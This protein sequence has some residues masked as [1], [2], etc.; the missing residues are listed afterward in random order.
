LTPATSNATASTANPTDRPVDPWPRRM[1]FL[2]VA[3]VAACLGAIRLTAPANL[4]DQDQERPA[5]YVLDA[6]KNGNWICQRDL[7][8]DI[9]SKP[10]LYTWFCAALTV[11]NGRINLATLYLPCVFAGFGVAWL[12]LVVGRKP[13]GTTAAMFGALMFMLTPAGLKLFGLARTDSLFALTVTAAALLAWRAWNRG[14]GWTWFWLLAALATLTKGPL[15]VVL[16]AFGLLAAVWERRSGVAQPVKGSHWLGAALFFLI[17][18]GWFYLAYLDQGQALVDKM[19]GKELVGNAIQNKKN[20]LPGTLIWQQPLFYLGRAAPWSLLA[21]CGVWRIWKR[22]SKQALER[23]FERFLCCWFLAGL[24]LFSLSSHQRADLLWPLMPAAAL[25]AGRELA[26][27]AA[28]FPA[29]RLR[30]GTLISVALLLIGFGIYYHLGRLRQPAIQRTLALRNF[31]EKFEAQAGPE[32]P[33]TFLAAAGAQQPDAPPALQVYLNVYRRPV[34][35]ERAAGLLRGSEAA[36]VA[37]DDPGKL[38]HWCHPGDPPLLTVLGGD[39]GR[40][41]QTRIVGNRPG[42]SPHRGYAL[43]YGPF[44]VRTTNARLLLATQRLLR[45]RAESDACSVVA[46]NTSAVAAPIRVEILQGER[47]QKQE[48]ILASCE[49]WTVTL[50]R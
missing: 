36:F 43:A 24:F 8:G 22:P 48:R 32:F 11:A 44:D 5:T 21:C 45:V 37:L 4:L 19:I 46:S 47:R 23:R 17:T 12:L 6:V 16:S 3:V 26:R 9:T 20:I 35:A 50:D 28:R 42:F 39:G 38:A 1:P 27:W 49:S 40:G 13:F 10:P 25:I 15:G 2:L 14:G 41:L 30:C 29:R 33:L 31:A 7:S 18:A 34:S